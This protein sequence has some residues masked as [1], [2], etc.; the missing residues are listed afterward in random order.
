MPSTS[1][2]PRPVAKAVLINAT[3]SLMLTT[4][5]NPAGLPI[6]VFDKLHTGVQADCSK[7]WKDLSLPFYGY[8]RPG[9][10]ISDGSKE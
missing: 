1:A 6:E 2:T 7:F 5:A 3:P 10:K 9:A 8:N 4:A